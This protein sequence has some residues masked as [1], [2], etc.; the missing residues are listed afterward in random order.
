MEPGFC[1]VCRVGLKLLASSDL[2]ALAFQSAGITESHSVT[3]HQA[4]VQWHDLGS[5]QPPP[6]GFKQFSCLSLPSSWDYS[7]PSSSGGQDLLRVQHQLLEQMHQPLHCSHLIVVQ[8]EGPVDAGELG[9]GCPGVG[10]LTLLP[11][12]EHS[13][14]IMVHCSLNLLRLS[15][16]LFLCPLAFIVAVVRSDSLEFWHLLDWYFHQFWKTNN[17]LLF[18][19]TE[20]CSVA[21]AECTGMISAHCNP[22]LLGSSNSHA[23]ASQV[24]R[25]TGIYH[26][27]QLIFAFSVEAGFGPV[28]Q[29][30]SGDSQA[31]ASRV[32]GFANSLTLLPRL[33]CSGNISAQCNLRLPGS[34]DSLASASHVAEITGMCNHTQ[35]IFIF[36]VEM[37]FHCVDQVGLKLLASNEV[38]LLLLRLEYNGTISAH[39]NL[40]LPGSS[41]SLA[42][43]S[44]VAGT[45]GKHHHAQL[46][47]CR[48]WV[49][50]C[51]SGWSQTPDL[52]AYQMEPS[53]LALLLRLECSGM[54]SAPCNFHLQGSRASYV[55]AS[56]VAG[57]TGAHHHICLIFI[58]LVE[59]GF[60]R[61]DQAGLELLTSSNLPTSASQSAGITGPAKQTPSSE[62]WVSAPQNPSC[63]SETPAPAKQWHL[64]RL[65]G[66]LLH[67]PSWSAVAR[68]WLTVTSASWVPVQAI[69]LPQPPKLLELQA[70][71]TM[72][73]GHNHP[74]RAFQPRLGHASVEEPT[75]VDQVGRARWLM[76]VS[77]ALWEAGGSPE[78]RSSRPAW[79][80]WQN[81]ISTK[82]TKISQAW[83]CAPVIPATWEAEAGEL[84][85]PGRP[86]LQ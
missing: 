10:N 85:E 81:P 38:S 24:V 29:D 45:T 75:E 56:R 50:P 43:A 37:G 36:L 34:S 44:Q 62:V 74:D 13:D 33:E 57:I 7:W 23:P 30:G 28:G 53:S 55:A 71:A 39:C 2:P 79:P 61:D 18:F 48:D 17:S 9:D 42:S 26:N 59:T 22:C 41:N 16:I 86:K 5:L 40:H 73:L 70:C 66:V 46:I 58:F 1:Q 15:I 69:L 19:E 72:T 6:P 27:I 32:A 4:G 21:Q 77:P 76:P 35:L 52:R 80:T 49:S 31:S 83:Y 14:M 3:R 65:D 54:I 47:F 63:S 12:L 25:I 82:N 20:S 60:P 8:N 68:S 64:R 51:W 11:R 84:L 78:V 67:S